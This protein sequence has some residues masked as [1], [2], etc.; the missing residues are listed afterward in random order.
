MIW[1]EPFSAVLLVLTCLWGPFMA[2]QSA[3]RLGDGPLPMTRRRFFIQ[4]IVIQ[5]LLFGVAVTAAWRTGVPLSVAPPS[6]LVH[7]E[8]GWG[9]G[10]SEGSKPGMFRQ[11]N[12]GRD[13]RLGPFLILRSQPP[14]T[15][16]QDE[17]NATLTP[18]LIVAALV[19]LGVLMLRWRWPSRTTANKYRLYSILPHSAREF[20]SYLVLC[21]AAGI[22]EEVVYRGMLFAILAYLT[23]SQL[24]A[25]LIASVVFAL[26]HAVQGLRGVVA[27]F[28]IALAAH[29][30]VLFAHSLL[31]AIL[32]HTVYD[33]VAG[34]LIPR[35]YERDMKLSS[36]SCAPA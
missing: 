12:V 17:L 11:E 28:L 5:A 27:I 14:T 36:T 35:L 9:L 3:R 33:A 20:P 32:A 21:L 19:L 31:P 16:A 8:R 29:G 26:A 22:G 4:T 34:W 2:I 18:W 7:P 24:A 25:V 23:G 1:L 30:L 15:R 10:G 6:A 13:L